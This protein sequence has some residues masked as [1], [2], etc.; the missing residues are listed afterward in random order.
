MPRLRARSPLVS[1]I[2]SIDLLTVDGC[3][4][5]AQCA[6]DHDLSDAIVDSSAASY[7][8]VSCACD[9]NATLSSPVARPDA[10]PRAKC[11]A[12]ILTLCWQVPKAMRTVG[13][14]RSM[15]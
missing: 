4:E 3:A 11:G 1:S 12:P 10:H 13:P 8:D 2:E 14:E 15:R 6:L 7:L 5:L 9:A